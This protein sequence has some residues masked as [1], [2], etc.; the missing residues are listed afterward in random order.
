MHE[1]KFANDVLD[2]ANT[3]GDE[4]TWIGSFVRDPDN[5]SWKGVSK[6]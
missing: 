1:S 4:E 3:V 2:L 5:G 6:H